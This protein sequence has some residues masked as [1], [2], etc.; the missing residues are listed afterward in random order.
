[1]ML[2]ILGSLTLLQLD[3]NRVAVFIL[4]YLFGIAGNAAIVYGHCKQIKDL[5][6]D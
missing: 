5:V 6:S 2:V 1:M 4:E 3:L